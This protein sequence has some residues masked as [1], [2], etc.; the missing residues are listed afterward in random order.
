MWERYCR[1]V[2]AI[3]FMVDA[4]NHEMMI[5]SKAELHALLTRPQLDNIPVLVLGNKTDLPGALDTKTLID[6][7]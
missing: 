1:G 7:L 4:A 2:N 5:E 3:L 6:T